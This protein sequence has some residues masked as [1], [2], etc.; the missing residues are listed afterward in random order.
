[1]LEDGEML[2][3]LSPFEA[4]KE[5]ERRG[6]DLVEISPKAVPPVCKIMDYGKFKYEQKKKAHGTR[7]TNVGNVV[8]EITLSPSTDVHDVNFKVRNSA[9]FLDEGYRVKI[10]VKF[11]G[12]EMAHPEVG[13]QQMDKIIE[14][15]KEHGVPEAYP[16]MEGKVL[17]ANFVP[18][19]PAV[20][21][22]L[23]NKGA[24]TASPTGAPAP[25]S[26]NTTPPAPAK[27]PNLG[28]SLGSSLAAKAGKK[29]GQK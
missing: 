4:M 1:V 26:A 18:L 21:A 29:T 5:A 8:K 7:K 14:M 6:L 10:A 20:K 27:G 3:V 16:K 15:L 25:G 12:R 2:G 19:T 22:K 13:R 9:R 23:V 24:Q 11:R 17:A 28:N